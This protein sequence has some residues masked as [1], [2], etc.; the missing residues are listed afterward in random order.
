MAYKLRETNF[1]IALL[2]LQYAD[3]S[4]AFVLS[5]RN[6]QRYADVSSTNRLAKALNAI[7]TQKRSSQIPEDADTEYGNLDNRGSWGY[8]FGKVEEESDDMAGY[9][10]KGYDEDVDMY[11]DYPGEDS[12]GKL[13][14][15]YYGG[16]YPGD[17]GISHFII[18]NLQIM[19][20]ILK[21]FNIVKMGI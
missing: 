12:V 7:Q 9:G 20:L 8:P 10:G 15:Y 18:T 21:H 4:G 1:L 2:C 16:G 13:L 5:K 3:L 6:Q 11:Y 19:Y 14:E 17:D